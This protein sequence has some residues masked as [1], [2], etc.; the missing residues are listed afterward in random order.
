M[1]NNNNKNIN[2]NIS[3]NKNTN[4]TKNTNIS[5][6]KNISKNMNKNFNKKKRGGGKTIC[7]VVSEI[8]FVL[9]AVEFLAYRSLTWPE[10]M[11]GK[12]NNFETQQQLERMHRL[13]TPQAHRRQQKQKQ[14]QQ[15]SSTTTTTTAAN[16]TTITATQQQQ[17][18]QQQHGNDN[19]NS[20]IAAE[21]QKTVDKLKQMG[22]PG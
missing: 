19:D 12:D 2:T 8:M 21:R 6:N 15:S 18:Q 22:I 16:K 5:K 11:E 14:Q 20:H 13:V 1:S 10:D 7:R 4:I 3:K 17:Q 9:I